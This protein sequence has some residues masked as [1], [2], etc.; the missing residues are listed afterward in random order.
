[1]TFMIK[2]PVHL[3]PDEETIKKMLEESLPRIIDYPIDKYIGLD[4]PRQKEVMDSVVDSL[5]E[6]QSQIPQS[7]DVLQAAVQ[8]ITDAHIEGKETG[9]YSHEGAAIGCL[10][11]AAIGGAFGGFAGASFGCTGG[12]LIGRAIG[13]RRKFALQ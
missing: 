7:A 3:N 6:L 4:P 12:G 10:V 2:W 11:G 8:G 1:M 5:Q 13:E 9:T